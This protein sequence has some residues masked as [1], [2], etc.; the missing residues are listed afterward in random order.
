M[1]FLCNL[2]MCSEPVQACWVI[3]TSS[4]FGILWPFKESS[5]RCLCSGCKAGLPFSNQLLLHRGLPLPV[6]YKVLKGQGDTPSPL[7]PH[8]YYK[9]LNAVCLALCVFSEERT[10]A[11]FKSLLG[12]W[13]EACFSVWFF[14]KHL[15]ISKQKV[16]TLMLRDGEICWKWTI[17]LLRHLRPNLLPCTADMTLK[18]WLYLSKTELKLNKNSDSSSHR[19]LL[20]LTSKCYLAQKRSHSS[21][22]MSTQ[23][24]VTLVN[25]GYSQESL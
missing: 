14:K 17:Q 11:F 20:W 13:G 4:P 18:N 5:F 15:S 24:E 6:I 1:M 16:M 2:R 7:V 12:C 23:K 22:S 10:F 19:M 25:R 3:H 21:H 9:P 8:L